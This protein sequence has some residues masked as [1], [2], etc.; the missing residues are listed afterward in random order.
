MK[1]LL[2]ILTIFYINN[3]YAQVVN[4]TKNEFDSLIHRY[5]SRNLAPPI[6]ND[7]DVMNSGFAICK[8]FKD[9]SVL[10]FAILCISDTNYNFAISKGFIGRLNSAYNSFS[11]SNFSIILPILIFNESDEEIVSELEKKINVNLKILKLKT[12]KIYKPIV[13]KIY[14]PIRK[15]ELMD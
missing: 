9:D 4:P 5:I 14:N 15:R 11:A 2:S 7:F 1:I 8:V 6:N 13:L 3:Q 10:K 12:R